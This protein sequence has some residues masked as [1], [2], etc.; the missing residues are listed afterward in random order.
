MQAFENHTI[1]PP[2]YFKLNDVTFVP[3]TLVEMYAVPKYREGNPALLTI[4]TFPFLFGMMFGDVGHGLLWLITGLMMCAVSDRVK[5]TSAEGMNQ[6][7]FFVCLMGLFATYCGFVYN[8]F[9]A[10]QMNMWGSCYDLNNPEWIRPDQYRLENDFQIVRKPN[11]GNCVYPFGQDPA[12][13]I[14]TN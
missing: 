3:Q 8:E 13:S 6:L 9:F 4:I 5:G 14:G 2:T 11:D 12:F 10:I 7:R 1:K